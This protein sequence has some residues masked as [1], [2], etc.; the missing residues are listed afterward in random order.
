M[1]TRYQ[2]IFS[3]WAC[4]GHWDW[5][6]TPE[7]L[8]RATRTTLPEE[9]NTTRRT[10]SVSQRTLLT[11]C[12]SHSYNAA[13]ITCL[14]KLLAY[15]LL[16]HLCLILNTGNSLQL[17]FKQCE[18]IFKNH[19]K[20]TKEEAKFLAES[21]KLQSRSLVWHEH[22]MGRLTASKFEAIYLSYKSLSTPALR[23]GLDNEENAKEAYCKIV[24]DTHEYF[25]LHSTGLHVNPVYPHLGVSPDRLVSCSCC[26][27]G[28]LEIKCPYSVR[29]E[30]PTKV[31][32][33]TFCLKPCAG[34]LKLSQ[35]H[36]YYY[37]IQGQM[38]VCDV[39]YCDS[40]C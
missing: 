16:S 13:R 28:V 18:R 33:S 31:Q 35:S 12:C 11:I 40:V 1:I 26:G 39:R 22:R 3:A 9:Q 19:L 17:T 7:T 20:V 34:S 36:Y 29:N 30:D 24:T 37:Q 6:S 32:R 2:F 27:E 15:Q 25:V 23:W 10:E 21:T 4:S 38:M 5:F 14:K 8:K